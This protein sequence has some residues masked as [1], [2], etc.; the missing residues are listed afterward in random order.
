MGEEPRIEDQLK[1]MI[2]E[3]LFLQ[4]EPAEIQD[5]DV[6]AERFG[7]D[8]V[9]LFE[10][11]VGAEEVFG[12]TFEDADFSPELFKDVTSIAAV[13]RQKLEGGQEKTGTDEE[14]NEREQEKAE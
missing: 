5:D 12:I 1:A 6:L 10:I 3:R 2:V 11:V 4:V 8:S 13:V 7:I 14:E 9:Q